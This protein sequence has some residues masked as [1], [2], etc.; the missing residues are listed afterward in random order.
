M[1]IASLEKPI[2]AHIWPFW[3]ICFANSDDIFCD[4]FKNNITAEKG[5]LTEV[6]VESHRRGRSA[7][8]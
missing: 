6:T 2:P 3:Q 7:A 5:N 4:L 8:N 1:R